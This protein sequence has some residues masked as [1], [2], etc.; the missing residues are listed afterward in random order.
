[1][2]PFLSFPAFCLCFLFLAM[3]FGRIPLF[4]HLN[5]GQ[6]SNSFVA[7]VRKI[8]H[9]ILV[10]PKRSFKLPAFIALSAAGHSVILSSCQLILLSENQD[11]S[12]SSTATYLRTSI[13]LVLLLSF[14]AGLVGI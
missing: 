10:F 13:G 5:Q 9:Q 7:F 12:V 2:F 6:L 11:D 3:H 8:S 1:M 14:F 4:N